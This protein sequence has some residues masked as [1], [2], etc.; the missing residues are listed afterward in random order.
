MSVLLA[1]YAGEVPEKV[2]AIIERSSAR[3][4]QM[5][6]LISNIMDLSRLEAGQLVSEMK[7]TSLEP[8]IKNAL[9][10]VAGE[11]EQKKIT[12]NHQG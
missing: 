4:M 2:R 6:E 7:E 11:A 1:G 5:I 10:V 9:E 3:V 12:L 8:P